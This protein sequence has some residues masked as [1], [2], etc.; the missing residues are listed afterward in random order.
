MLF[1]FH[2]VHQE[3]DCH[4][5][6]DKNRGLIS[7]KGKENIVF[8]FFDG[9]SAKQGTSAK[10]IDKSVIVSLQFDQSRW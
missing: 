3:K 9:L 7:I 6:S 8:G 4:D 1:V 2:Q 5:R 10:V